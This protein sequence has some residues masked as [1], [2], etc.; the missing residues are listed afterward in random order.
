MTK[1][2]TLILIFII[3]LISFVLLW[4][5]PAPALA[6]TPATPTADLSDIIKVT[7]PLPDSV[8]TSP[9]TVIGQARGNWSFEAQFPVKLYDN[10]GNLLAATGAW[11]QGDWMTANFMPF[12][13]TLIFTP[14]TGAT[15]GKLIL[16][17]DNPSGLP[18]NDDQLEIPV[19]F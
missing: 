18:K 17:K 5:F 8:I 9:L 14:P 4:R 2:N 6:P 10:S 12:T 3:L 11:I 13:A 1:K 7:A 15:Q 19:Q 16:E